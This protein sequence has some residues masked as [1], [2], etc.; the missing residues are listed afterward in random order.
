[1]RIF[2]TIA[3]VVLCM[4]LVT[5]APAFSQEGTQDR[6]GDQK[7]RDKDD[8]GHEARQND[9]NGRQDDNRRD[10]SR[11][12]ARPQDNRDRGDARQQEQARPEDRR[13][14]NVGRQE[15]GRQDEGR[16]GQG[17]VEDR[18]RA[19]SAGGQG[20]AGERR[21][22]RIPEE[23]FRASFGREH[24]FR[25]DRARIVN[26]AQPVFVYSG[27]SFELAEAWPAEWGFDDECYVDYVDNDYYLYD[28]YHPGIRI[29]VFVIGD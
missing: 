26:Q 19:R 18:D 16:Q 24:H 23:R 22:M 20:R 11:R 2:A 10:D 14:E 12:E 8:K 15:E 29:L 4:C 7:S 9:Q 17:R 13:N 28:V 21:G 27:Y 25:V 3:A 1:M 6:P 5:S